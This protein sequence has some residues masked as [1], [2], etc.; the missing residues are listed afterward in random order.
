M[1]LLTDAIR[2]FWGRMNAAGIKIA[3]LYAIASGQA[4]IDEEVLRPAIRLVEWHQQ[5]AIGFL[6]ALAPTQFAKQLN[7]VM[8]IVRRQGD[9]KPVSRR[10]I[11]RYARLA[12]R[13]LNDVLTTLMQGGQLESVDGPRGGAAYVEVST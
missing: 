7:R 10:D 11:T 3:T 6:D 4:S 13:E 9:G 2:A 5:M 1:R 12:P 8:E